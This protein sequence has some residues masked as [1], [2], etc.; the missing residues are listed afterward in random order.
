MKKLLTFLLVLVTLVSLASCEY[1]PED[2]Q[3]T[4]GGAVDNISGMISGII[5]GEQPGPTPDD[6]PVHTHDFVVYESKKAFCAK[7]GYAKSKCECGETKEEVIPALGHDMQPV[8]TKPTCIKAG[9]EGFACTRCSKTDIHTVE[10]L[11]HEWGE[12][13]ESS[14]VITCT[15]KGCTKTKLSE[16]NGKYAETLAFTFGDDDKATLEAKHNELAAILEAADKYNEELHGL[17]TEGE[18]FDAYSVAEALYE[19]YSD[20]IFDAQ[21]Q[22]SIAMTLY[23]CNHRN[24]EL[25]NRYNDM[26]TYYTDLVAKFYSL[27]QPWYDSMFR[28]FFFEGATEEEINAFLFDSNALADE[29]YTKLKNRND[30]I[31]LEFNGLSNPGS[32]SK[33]P[34]LYAEF[35]KNNNAMAIRLGYANYLEYA[36]E[37]VYDRDYTY[38][39]AGKFVDY[40]KEYIA[41]V[42][43]SV[44]EKWGSLTGGSIDDSDIETYYSV[45][46]NSFFFD[47][48]GNKLFNDYIDNMNMAF[49][50]N[51]DKQIS[52]SDCL[53]DL[54][55]DGNLFRGTYE[56]AYVTY[57]RGV[58]LPIAYFGKGYDSSTTVAHEFGHYMNEIYND[59]EYSQS[60]DL[61]ETHSQGQEMLYVQ[62]AKT[63]ISGTAI[64]LI[65]TYHILSSIQTI[66]LATQVTC[67]EQAIY[68]DHYEG[69]NS[70]VIMADGTITSDEYDDVYAGLSEYLGID[71]A[72]RVDEYWRHVTISSPCYYIS[73]AVSGVNALQIY[74]D[75]NIKGFDVAKDSYLKLFTYTDVDPEM[76]LEEI[77]TYA[78]LTSYVD[79]QTFVRIKNLL[80]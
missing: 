74:V 63:K 18:L 11:G 45:V 72:Y 40:V 4:L 61:L 27:S 5:G 12:F 44:Y 2:L 69:P 70:D 47:G 13:V 79:E 20:L 15:R 60:F 55:A 46:S 24:E 54:M 19:E 30:A 56:G 37:N 34:E 10:A 22:Y 29:E 43:N 58:D 42:Y 75:V 66:M 80:G 33:V 67:F 50:S 65:E 73:Y 35:V 57:I 78:G 8:S 59:D 3:S 52:F 21:G 51:P 23:Y 64:D 49:T 1:L 25:E 62:Y 26:Q 77:L 32:S 76:T 39:D 41:P 53:N 38:E 7:D 16:G 17:T 14:R 9:T 68:L 31:E 48:F 71:D 36:Y 28:E 6:K